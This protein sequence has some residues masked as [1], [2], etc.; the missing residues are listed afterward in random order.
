[1]RLIA[2]LALCAA[3]G[4]SDP[5]LDI[6][7]ALGKIPGLTVTRDHG[8]GNGLQRVDFTFTQP[9]DHNGK[10]QRSFAQRGFM[11]HR[12][13]KAP[14]V[15]E[16]EGYELP[17]VATPDEL[18]A[19]LGGNQIHLEHR[20]FH[21][22]PHPQSNDDWKFLTIQQAAA[23][24]H[25]F[26]KALKTLYLKKW[27]ATGASKGGETAVYFR[28]FYPNDVDATVAYVA[29]FCVGLRD[30][31]FAPFIAA[32][33]GGRY[34]QALTDVM[35]RV[36]QNRGNFD[37]ILSTTAQADGLVFTLY[38]P[39]QALEYAV[40]GI[41]FTLWQYFDS[42]FADNAPTATSTDPY[43]FNWVANVGVLL[44]YDDADVRYFGPYDYQVDTQLGG[45]DEDD[46]AI[47]DLLAHQSEPDPS[48]PS[49][50]PTPFDA[51]SMPDIID[52]V[53]TEAQHIMFVYGENDP[54]TAGA[55]T[56][57]AGPNAKYLAPNGNHLSTIAR[58]SDADRADAA[59]KLSSWL[60]IAVQAPAAQAESVAREDGRAIR[61]R[62]H[63][64]FH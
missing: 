30:A 18:A 55:V 1:M 15:F 5:D 54:W 38:P 61:Y 46:S 45:P 64:R 63:H 41:P 20:F 36:L 39:D 58:L 62:L 44:F 19:M 6:A 50:L 59:A 56:L 28:R 23:D 40:Q 26:V 13:V 35:R 43:T 60:G 3:C 31:R 9:L 21:D 17:E 37:G 48:L 25:A 10:H 7:A 52:W 14:V 24:H 29:P 53:S 22:N 27:I 11:L 47:A 16:T 12:S 4:Q 2:L 51:T 57:G 33:A 8:V 49:D 34:N 42:S 32:R